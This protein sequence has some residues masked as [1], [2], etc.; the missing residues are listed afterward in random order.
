MTEYLQLLAAV[1]AAL[2]IYS[3]GRWAMY[4]L[5]GRI[6]QRELLTVLEF[7]MALLALTVF[8]AASPP[9]LGLHNMY[10][11]LL[12]LF[13]VTTSVL[14]LGARHLLEE[15]LTGTFAL[16]A[17]NLHVGDYIEV[18]HV[19]GYITQVEEAYIVVR[20]PKKELIHIPYTYLIHRP[21]RK[22]R[23]EEG[24]EV[25]IPLFLPYGHDLRRVRDVIQS[26]AVEYGLE[27]LRV[28]VDSVEPRGAVLVVRGIM[29]DPRREDEARY[30]I[31]DKVYSE[32]G[33][34]RQS[35]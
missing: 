27:N 7:A 5:F 16:R 15:F 30:A 11:L 2:S 21:F 35:P 18:E 33:P 23:A 19:K 13:L 24:H 4:R 17:F 25:R 22:I 29:R 1:A 14:V 34:I 26:V 3:V 28:D 6:L 20:D 8:T 12:A 9:A 32:V 10:Y 31:L